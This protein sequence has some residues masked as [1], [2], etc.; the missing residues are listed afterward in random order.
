ML[1]AANGENC[2]I[3]LIG[4][5]VPVVCSSVDRGFNETTVVPACVM[6]DPRRRQGKNAVDVCSQIVSHVEYRRVPG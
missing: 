4:G 5:N 3:S 1:D 6:L 2:V